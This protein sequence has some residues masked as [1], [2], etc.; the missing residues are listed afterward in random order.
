MEKKKKLLLLFGGLAVLAII[1]GAI[2]RNRNAEDELPRVSWVEV[3]AKS[4]QETVS[5]SGDFVSLRRTT[6]QSSIPGRIETIHISDGDE[7]ESGDI[8]LSLDERDYRNAMDQ[9]RVAYETVLRRTQEELLGLRQSYIQSRDAE[10]RA[11]DLEERTRN[12]FELGSVSR[13]DWLQAEEGLQNAVMASE[14]ARQRVNLSLG[15]PLDREPPEDIESYKS[16]VIHAP[17]VRGAALSVQAAM[18]E[19]NHCT[20]RAPEDGFITGLNLHPGDAVTPQTL[21]FRIESLD[22]MIAE[23]TIDEVDIGKIAVGDPVSITSDSLVGN[24]LIGEVLSIAPVVERIGN[25]RAAVVKTSVEGNDSIL[26][27]GASC[28]VK[29]EVSSRLPETVI[30]VTAFFSH[31]GALWAY[32]IVEET[33]DDGFSR[34]VLE[35]SLVELGRSSLDEVVVTSGLSAGDRVVTGNLSNLRDGI[36]VE[37]AA[38]DESP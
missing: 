11:R 31:T 38:D 2:F 36:A 20:I 5:G 16:A 30:P 32:R 24:S 4:L 9:A 1:I 28:L 33:G 15:T 26:R 10:I 7:V 27:A 8:L 35:K 22:E 3:E 6:L 13:E 37:L 17:E 14:S 18:D 19:V 34:T 21:L 12:L 23:I 25:L 29:I